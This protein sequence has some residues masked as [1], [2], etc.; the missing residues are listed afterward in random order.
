MKLHSS[1]FIFHYP[2]P[3]QFK[4]RPINFNVQQLLTD[5]N[6][7]SSKNFLKIFKATNKLVDLNQQRYSA[8]F[9]LRVS[10]ELISWSRPAHCH[11]IFLCWFQFLRIENVRRDRNVRKN[12]LSH[13]V[14][15]CEISHRNEFEIVPWMPISIKSSF[16]LVCS[17]KILVVVVVNVLIKIYLRWHLSILDSIYLRFVVWRNQQ[18]NF[19]IK[20]YVYCAEKK[21]WWTLNTNE[22]WRRTSKWTSIL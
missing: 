7:F 5:W 1:I 20:K 3:V 4:V 14:C 10:Q 13:T 17:K 19:T 6:E 15:A 12:F 16:V 18:K 22:W 2:F 11:H 8:L 9:I 21:I